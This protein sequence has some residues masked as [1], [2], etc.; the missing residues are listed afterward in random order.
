VDAIEAEYKRRKKIDPKAADKWLDTAL[1]SD[2]DDDDLDDEV[3]VRE[4]RREL[5]TGAALVH[6]IHGGNPDPSVGYK[7]GYALFHLCLTLGDVPDHDAWC[8]IRSEALDGVDAFLK[9]AG[10]KPKSF[11]VDEFLVNRG[12]PVPMPRPEDFPS[13]GYLER[14]EVPAVLALLAPARLDPVLAKQTA[15]KRDWLGEMTAELRSWVEACAR[16]ERDLVSFYF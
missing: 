7:Y 8:S 2:D 5:S 15:R 11:T 10:V 16:A 14:D 1:S 3:E 9:A 6:L 12:P 4:P 13:I